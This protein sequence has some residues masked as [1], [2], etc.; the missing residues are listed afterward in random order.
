[1]ATRPPNFVLILCDDLGYGDIEPYGGSIPTPALNRM[2]EEGLTATDYYCPAN[3]CTPSRAGI[4]TGR[5]PVRTGLGYEVIFPG[6]DRALPLSEPT[7]AAALKPDYVSGIFGKWHLGHAGPSWLPTNYGFDTFAGIPY[8]HDMLPLEF[9]EADAATGAV[10][11]TP[12]DFP[13]L[14][15]QIYEHAERF[16]ERHRDRPFFV[17]L[18]LS[19][20]HLPEYPFGEFKGS[21]AAG[22]YGDVVREIDAITGRLLDSLKALEIERETLVIFTS[23]NG[24][25]YEGS[26]GPLRDRKGGAGYDGGYRV[27]FIVWAPGRVEPGGTTDAIIGGIDLLPT[28]CALAGC[29]LPEDVELD[30]R[31]ISPVLTAGA[32]SPHEEILLFNNEDVVA[33]RTQAWKYIDRSYY[34]SLMVS[35]ARTGFTQLHDMTRDVAESYSVA[36]TYPE[37]AL[38]MQ[39]RLQRA[40]ETFAPFKRGMPPFFEELRK[41]GRFRSQD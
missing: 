7:I 41:Q 32:T 10:S 4:L 38:D 11:C 35:Y 19:A 6:E 27:P 15:Q 24:P 39:T 28:F 18:A 30:G 31:D 29:A 22:P 1:M 20:P 25:W 13:A 14:Q 34:R 9:Y 40:R 17:E 37:V 12:V 2:A 21:S 5:Y 26:T 33:V 23:D 36:E 16:I 3:I 8:S